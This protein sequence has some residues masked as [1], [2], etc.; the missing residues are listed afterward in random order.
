MSFSTKEVRRESR[1]LSFAKAT[2]E[3]SE[4]L[5]RTTITTLKSAKTLLL[6]AEATFA[7]HV[8]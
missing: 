5:H 3:S 6:H 2:L 7:K 8:E 1:L 4:T